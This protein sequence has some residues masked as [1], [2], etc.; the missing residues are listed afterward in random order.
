MNLV[1][2]IVSLPSG[3]HVRILHIDARDDLAWVIHLSEPKALPVAMQWATVAEL[4]KVT[5]AA[6][7]AEAPLR[8][9]AAA[10]AARDA[11]YQHI[12]P[13]V[14]DPAVFRPSTRGP[15]VAARARELG[16]SKQTLMA[17]LR[18]WWVG[19]QAKDSLM[20][21]F[22]RRGRTQG[23]RAR[24]PRGRK[25]SLVSYDR[26]VVQEADEAAMKEAMAHYLSAGIV[27]VPAAYD[28]L[29]QHHY[30]YLDGNQQRHVKGLGEC[31]TLKQF[32]Y[33]VNAQSTLSQRLKLRTARKRFEQ[34]SRGITGSV[35]I[36][37][38]GVG[39]IYEIDATIAD[40]LLVSKTSRQ[41]IVGKPTLYL[42]IDRRSR[43][44]VGF[45]VGLESASWVGAM[46]AI[47]S[48][49]E[50]KA[51][52]CARYNVP[53]DPEDWPAHG[54]LPQQFLADRGEMASQNSTRVCEGLEQT[55]ANLP[56]YR[57]DLKPLVESGFRS[58]HAALA[59]VTPGY[60]PPWNAKS[61]ANDP[62]YARD[63][64]L[65]LDEFTAVVMLEIIKS[66]RT[67]RPKLKLSGQEL[68]DGLRPVPREIWNYD[69][70]NNAG[71]LSRMSE[72][73]VR[74]ALLPQGTATVDGRG[75]RFADCYY[76]S[77]DAWARDWF[78]RARRSSFKVQVSYDPRLVDAVFVHDPQDPRRFLTVQLTRPYEHFAGL[79]FSEVKFLARANKAAF[80]NADQDA[81]DATFQFREG[82]QAVTEPALKSMKAV[83]KGMSRSARRADIAQV[84]ED[85]RRQ[86]R[87]ERAAPAVAALPS[88]SEAPNPVVPKPVAAVEATPSAPRPKLVVVAPVAVP[89]D[90]PLPA[91]PAAARPMT[92]AEKL[93]AKR[94]QMLNGQL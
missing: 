26:Y 39:H 14:S 76:E 34:N 93:R 55:V 74:F 58:T 66:N 64:S 30:T 9:S 37:C 27:S 88:P 22:D 21:S 42:V 91:V 60:D 15:L 6:G 13:L 77:E 28:W 5:G 92:L 20:P 1:N 44:I 47:L 63:A 41:L 56:G 83:T 89:A 33:F 82:V 85:E 68:A 7:A 62:K 19:G 51:A 29:L 69:V 90:E 12:A 40:V 8:A 79:S 46:Q 84:R 87:Q 43:L 50:D 59:S 80:A 10:N 75:I 54:V 73:R 11:L 48:I 16:C 65:T 49:V 72:E 18:R 57:P 86:E 17:A 23:D 71:R 2:D 78:V 45:Y 61:R 3:R 94:E 53:F 32:R 52:L 70:R 67:P 24:A 31:P 25:P 4:P 38:L 35:D 81:R 36:D